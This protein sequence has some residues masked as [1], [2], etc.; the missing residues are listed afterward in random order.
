M[1]QLARQ[2]REQEEQRALEKKKAE[3]AKIKQS[4]EPIT[5][6]ERE[7]KRMFRKIMRRYELCCVAKNTLIFSM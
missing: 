4:Y 2:R 7:R 3:D 6:A 1:A 5:G